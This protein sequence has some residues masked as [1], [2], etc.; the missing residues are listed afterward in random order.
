MTQEEL[1]KILELHRRWLMG[2]GVCANLT[3]A[4][5][6]GVDLSGAD[7]RGANLSGVN[8]EGVNLEGANLTGANLSEAYLSSAY[9]R[10]ADLKGAILSEAF[11]C[12]AFLTGANLEGADLT[13]ADLTEAY[14]R[15]VNLKDAH[16][17][18]FQIPDGDLIGWKKIQGGVIV[19]LRIPKEAKRTGN[20]ISQKCRAEYADVLSFSKAAKG[21]TSIDHVPPAKVV[22]TYEVG[23]RVYPDSYDDDI[24]VQATH[25]IHFFL[26]RGEAEVW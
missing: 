9:L 15:G 1:Q 5:L 16:L 22:T 18:D 6:K 8:L 26:N 4:D 24:R 13:G 17:P 19:E 7:L 12:T 20:L 25:G 21:V 10:H 2:H 3:G 23:K 11:L 14:L